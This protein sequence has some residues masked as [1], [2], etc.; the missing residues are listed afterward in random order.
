MA[1]VTIEIIST[2]ASTDARAGVLSTPHGDVQT[3]IFMPVGTQGTVKGL[4]VSQIKALGA[5]MILGNTYHLGLRPGPDLIR[6][7]G[8]LHQFSGWDGPILTDSGGFQIFSLGDRT[9]ITEHAAEFRS[10]IDGRRF[11]LTPEHAMEIQQALGSDVAMVLDHVIA[12][13]AERSVR[14]Q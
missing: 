3:P 13:P 11:E 8:G 14:W 1:A 12:L 6:S 9:K 2:D 7:L 4:T 5:R 10:H